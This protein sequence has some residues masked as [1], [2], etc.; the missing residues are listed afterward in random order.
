MVA[1]TNRKKHKLAVL[2]GIPGV[3]KTTL[4]R[5]ELSTMMND[6]FIY[7]TD[8]YIEEMAKE[9]N[10]SYNYVFSDLIDD[11]VRVMNHDVERA[12]KERRDIIWDQT[13][14]GSKKRKKILARFPNTYYK[15]CCV[16][17]IPKTDEQK[18]LHIAYVN[19]RKDKTMTEKIMSDMVSRF[20]E[21]SLD[22]GWDYIDCLCIGGPHNVQAFPDGA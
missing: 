6:P 3:G 20:E 19:S 12:I 2:V 15:K 5:N 9:L 7:S 17:L 4:A 1:G 18:T 11:A 16:I 22:E 21:P 14:T 8:D 10:K 13:N